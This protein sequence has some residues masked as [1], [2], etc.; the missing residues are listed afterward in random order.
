MQW[1][2]TGSFSFVYPPVFPFVRPDFIAFLCGFAVFSS[3]ILFQRFQKFQKSYNN[4]QVYWFLAATKIP[5]AKNTR[6]TKNHC[7]WLKPIV[8]AA[9]SRTFFLIHY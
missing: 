8:F 7:S 4:A 3:E 6:V 9:F 1:F 5:P 2:F